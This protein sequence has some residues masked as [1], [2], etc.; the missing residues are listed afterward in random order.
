[1]QIDY[2][3][4]IW[5]RITVHDEQEKVLEAL[6]SGSSI[7]NLYDNFYGVLSSV[8]AMFETEEIMTPEENGNQS[9]IE[10]LDD[11]GMTIYTNKE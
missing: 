1:M 6:K 8:D 3:A 5:F 2:K 10:V 7:E 4:T 9:T 11:L